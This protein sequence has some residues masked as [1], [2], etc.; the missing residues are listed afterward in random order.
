MSESGA[1][2]DRDRSGAPIDAGRGPG[3]VLVHGQPGAGGDWVALA[4]LLSSE[5]HVLAPDRPG[6]G[7]DPRSARGMVAN[8]DALEELLF[9]SGAPSRL[10]VVGHSLG[11]GIALELALKYP[12][13]VGALVLVG[14]VGVAEALSGFDRLLVVPMVG[15][16]ILRAGVATS[17]RGLIAATRYF[18]RYPQA[19]LARKVAV[20]PTLQAAIGSDGRP[21]IG[22]SRRSFLVEQRALLAETPQLERSLGRICVP[23][24]VVTGASD[25]IVP[26]SAARALQARV[27]GAELIV[28]PGGHLL[29]FERPDKLAEIV[30]RYVG[31]AMSFRDAP[32]RRERPEA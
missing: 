4:G 11:G 29:P 1:W 28:M 25:H 2:D 5:Y 20:L 18:E 23:T 7:S 13:R 22:R 32:L 21:I 19:R 26:T 9:S 6:W 12:E 10:T 16:G 8:A 27:P 14:S 31:L 3:V 17:R 24:A 30:R 15:S